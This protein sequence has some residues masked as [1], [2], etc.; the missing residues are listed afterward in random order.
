MY[1]IHSVNKEDFENE[2]KTGSYGRKI[3]E[4]SGFIHCSDL[5]TYYLVA[6]KFKDEDEKRL[7]LLIDTNKVSSEIKWEDGGGLTFPHIYGLLEKEAIVDVFDHL[8]SEDKTW[9]PNDELKK[10]ALNGF[11]RKI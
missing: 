6:P 8:W 2:I 10:Y 11:T 5:D 3:I 4:D 7:V 9:V 1:I